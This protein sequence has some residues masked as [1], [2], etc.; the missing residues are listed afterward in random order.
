ML[1]VPVKADYLHITV[2]VRDLSKTE[3]LRNT[4]AVGGLF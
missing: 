4:V 3:H 2:A 1:G